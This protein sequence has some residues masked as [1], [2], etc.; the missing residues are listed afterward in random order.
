LLPERVLG[1]FNRGLGK[2]D[3]AR[4]V[5]QFNQTYP[6]TPDAQDRIISRLT[7]PAS[8]SL[9]HNSHAL[10]LRLSRTR[11][12]CRLHIPRRSIQSL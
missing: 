7:L 9:D 1:Q 3:L 2:A 4:L 5:N 12:R 11:E 10:D 8:Y 6:A